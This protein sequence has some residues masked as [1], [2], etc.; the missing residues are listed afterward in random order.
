M[1]CGMLC[2]AMTATALQ[3]DM[4]TM[5][6]RLGVCCVLSPGQAEGPVASLA[7]EKPPDSAAL[8]FGI[9]QGHAAARNNALPASKTPRRLNSGSAETVQ[10]GVDNEERRDEP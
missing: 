2:R 5:R 6:P 1:I 9:Q 7:Y 8:A 10:S 3:L 4:T